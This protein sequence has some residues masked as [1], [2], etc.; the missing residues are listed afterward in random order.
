MACD[1]AGWCEGVSHM[2]CMVQDACGATIAR[3]GECAARVC[4]ESG[5][6]R[7]RRTRVAWTQYIRDAVTA[8]CICARDMH[9]A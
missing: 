3:R 9:K 7:A 5:E 2:A 8:G 4:E 6:K 1:A